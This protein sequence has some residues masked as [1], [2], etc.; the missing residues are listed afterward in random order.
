M[1]FDDA[2]NITNAY[3]EIVSLCWSITIIFFWIA[4]VLFLIL[5]L[6]Q[7][8]LENK[9]KIIENKK[10]A[11]ID[12]INLSF[13]DKNMLIEAKDDNDY[14]AL[15]EA[16]AEI[17]N[18]W[19]K[20]NRQPIYDII[21]RNRLD[22]YLLRKYKNSY[23]KFQK[24]SFFLKLVYLSYPHTK[25]FF[26]KKM[27]NN[28]FFMQKYALYAFAI[29]SNNKYDLENIA[30]AI[31]NNGLGDVGCKFCE[32][33]FEEAL[34]NTPLADIE[35]FVKNINRYNKMIAIN[36]LSAIANIK[37]E[38]AIVPITYIYENYK[39][40]EKF[41]IDTINL[42]SASNLKYCQIIKD[43]YLS[44][45]E[46]VR[47][48]CAKHAFNICDISAIDFLYI[49]FFDTNEDIRRNILVASKT[50]GLKS[51]DI[52]SIVDKRTHQMINDKFLMSSIFSW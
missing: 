52:L 25:S 26:L 33:V 36:I 23:F 11:Y 51:T 2:K 6:L 12:S 32:F 50:I 44:F 45:N 14:L 42:L 47:L 46:S 34:K 5:S 35:D 22:I 4:V 20:E 18:F 17:N 1:D 41:I 7:I 30:L 3:A 8:H 27:K 38:E 28:K 29:F 24:K 40:D 31:K 9:R 19:A 15:T 13:F 37:K 48:A 16:I 49:Y 21:K 43:N 39:N 10:L